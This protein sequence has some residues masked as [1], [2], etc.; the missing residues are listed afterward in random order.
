MLGKD[1]SVPGLNRDRIRVFLIRFQPGDQ[2]RPD[3]LDRLGIEPRLVYGKCEQPEGLIAIGGKG[4]E[5]A[6]EGIGIGGK[7]E[8]HR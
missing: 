1:G 3:P 4:S 7:A 6:S 5:T 2:L 8:T